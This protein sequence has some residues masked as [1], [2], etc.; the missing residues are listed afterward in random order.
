MKYC[1]DC[2]FIISIRAPNVFTEIVDFTR[3]W[4]NLY[5]QDF[6]IKRQI[7]NYFLFFNAIE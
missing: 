4:K 1:F 6:L 7:F 3:L 5:Q 2:V